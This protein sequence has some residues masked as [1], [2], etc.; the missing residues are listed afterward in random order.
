MKQ[1]GRSQMKVED[2]TD[3]AV[4]GLFRAAVV[5]EA[6]EWDVSVGAYRVVTLYLNPE[7]ARMLADQLCSCANGV[8][9]EGTIE[10]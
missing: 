1:T 4:V 6:N 3:F 7:D 2:T 5:L 10:H 8:D 9:P